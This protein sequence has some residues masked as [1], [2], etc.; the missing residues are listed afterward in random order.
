MFTFITTGYR[1]PSAMLNN[2]NKWRDVGSAYLNGEKILSMYLITHYLCMFVEF[3]GGLSNTQTCL[4]VACV[5]GTGPVAS[6]FHNKPHQRLTSG[7]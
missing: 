1:K 5:T 4:Q 3:T 6:S 2:S 7:V